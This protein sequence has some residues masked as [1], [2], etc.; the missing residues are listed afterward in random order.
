MG[1]LFRNIDTPVALSMAGKTNPGSSDFEWAHGG[2]R[3]LQGVQ[4]WTCTDFFKLRS[5]PRGVSRINIEYRHPQQ[6]RNTTQTQCRQSP[7]S[8]GARA[9][10]TYMWTDNDLSKN[11]PVD[12]QF[13]LLQYF[14]DNLGRFSIR[15]KKLF[16]LLTF[17]LD[18]VVFIQ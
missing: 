5:G 3:E 15:A 12:I 8:Y 4:I 11:H 14:S 16:T 13:H 2:R 9:R 1:R 6:R 7:R 17:G 10:R 18:P